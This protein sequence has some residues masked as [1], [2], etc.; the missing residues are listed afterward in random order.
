MAEITELQLSA[1]RNFLATLPHGKDIELVLLKGHLLI[2]EQVRLLIHRRL[3]NPSTVQEAN[4]RLEAHQA[5]QLARAFFPPDHLPDIWKATLK[6]NKLRN[7]IAHSLWAKG[8]L[9][10][11]VDAWVQ[12]VPTGFKDHPDPQLRFEFTLWSLFEAISALVDAPSAEVVH[13]QVPNGETAA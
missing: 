12:S 1:F 5:I 10:D 11:K 13:I 4:S 6:L 9:A 7:D 8:S 3:R 2:E